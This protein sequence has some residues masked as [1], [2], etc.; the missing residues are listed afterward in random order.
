MA[1]LVLATCLAGKGL[2]VLSKSAY[3]KEKGQPQTWLAFL[4]LSITASSLQ[5][6]LRRNLQHPVNTRY[7]LLTLQSSKFYNDVVIIA[8]LDHRLYFA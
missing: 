3:R 2:S 5:T 7:A 4:L 6:R 8:R 1:E